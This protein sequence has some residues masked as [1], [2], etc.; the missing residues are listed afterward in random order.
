MRK[1]NQ[2]QMPLMINTI[3]HPHAMELESISKILDDNPIINEWVL[4]DLTRNEIH[5]DTG[6]EGMSA[7]QVIRAAIIKQME[8]FSYDT[9]DIFSVTGYIRMFY[10]G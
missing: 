10:D 5:S 8:G 9:G 2:K 7:E 6:A 1:K 3:D 4:Q